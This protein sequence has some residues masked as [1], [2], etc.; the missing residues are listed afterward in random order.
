MDASD[1]WYAA[2]LLLKAEVMAPNPGSPLIDHQVRLMRA[3]DAETAYQR[4]LFLGRAEEHEY[5]NPYGEIVRWVFLGLHNL[6]LLDAATLTD[7]LEVYSW[8][9]RGDTGWTVTPKG[10]LP[11]F[12][13]LDPSATAG[14]ILGL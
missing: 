4:A 5:E 14:D 8:M 3:A 11:V 6:T 1:S 12:T 2:V 7:G 9:A 13:S 10:E